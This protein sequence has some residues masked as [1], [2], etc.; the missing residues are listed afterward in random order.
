[1]S[2]FS[3]AIGKT[4]R[5]KHW[6]NVKTSWRNLVKKLS[7][8]T[9]TLE[10]FAEYISFGK[11]RQSDI[12]DRGGFVGGYLD[13][14]G[15][16]PQNV[17]FRQLLTLDIDYAP[18]NFWQRFTLLYDYSAI[19]HSTHKH[20]KKSPRYR[21]IVPLD[22]RV[23]AEEYEAI[24]RK[25]AG[26]FGINL[27]DPTTFQP[28]RL[29]YWPTTAK[30]GEFIFE[31]QDGAYLC[32][33]DILDSYEDWTNIYDWPRPDSEKES[34]RT[35]LKKAGTPAEKPGLIGAFNRAFPI[36]LAI[37]EFLSDV[38]EPTSFDDRY[39]YAEGSGA[40]GAI[41][42]GEDEFLFS[43]HSTDPVQGVLCNSFDLVRL[44]KF[45][46]EDTDDG[47]KEI[48]KRRSYKL[49]S[50]FAAEISDVVK[51]IARVRLPSEVFDDTYNDK[52]LGSLTVDKYGQYEATIPNFYKILSNDVNMRGRFKTDLFNMRPVVCLPVPWNAE[53]EGTKDLEDGD[54]AAVR[55]YLE[56][57]YGIYHATKCKDAMDIVLNE[58]T[59][60]PVRDY[61]GALDWDGLKRLDTLLVDYL[62]AVDTQFVRLA[63]RKAF[64]AAVARIMQP[65][66]KFDYTLTLVGPEGIRKSTLPAKMGGQWFSDTFIGVEGKES[67]EQLHGVWIMEIAE[68]SSIRKA[69]AEP[70]KLFLA[71]QE[72]RF[73]P[74]YGHRT[75]TYKRQNIFIGSVNDYSFLK[76]NNGNR[77]FWPVDV[78]GFGRLDMDEM[79][80]D[81][82]WA[83]ACLYYK[84]GEKLYFDADVEEDART[85]QQAHTE[86]DERAG[87]VY[88][89][90]NVPLPKGWEKMGVF[91]RRS[92]LND[93]SQIAKE[94]ENKRVSLCAAEIWSEVFHGEI[95]QMTPYNTRDIHKIMSKIPGWEMTDKNITFPL[96]GRQRTY[97]RVDASLTHHNSRKA[98]RKDKK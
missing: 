87:L 16:H 83:E 67:Y 47:A 73:R 29:M 44:H 54:E 48:T 15:R 3:I 76:D 28:E 55:H 24:A 43:H 27:F 89:Y 45:G 85:A 30:D 49:M 14:G 53:A 75:S 13:E 81:E 42:Y 32:A 93:S 95:K 2:E 59:F 58:N 6:K 31:D 23:S 25:F 98:D 7:D 11:E 71:K 88:N 96:Y 92:Y 78:S 97:T 94:G 61:L 46:H 91:E 56:D 17:K 37:E 68:L 52:W 26:S 57:F 36:S 38:Y 82:I 66:I 33:D 34:V 10:T 5:T 80:V 40:A 35:S 63:T 4:R 65:G 64:V 79:P 39:T 20:S 21:L 18:Y 19:L 84:H 90:I 86:S 51:Q 62:G 8:T 60:H 70:V 50:D 9:Y 41:V 12:K 74:A 1:M 72:D 22:R 69:D 77:R